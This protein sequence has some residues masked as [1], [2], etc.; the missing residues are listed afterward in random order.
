MKGQRVNPEKLNPMEMNS[1]SSM[2]GMMSLLQKI[3]KG[4]RKYSVKLE[5]ITRNF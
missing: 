4:K 2:M 5:K 3:G 1:M